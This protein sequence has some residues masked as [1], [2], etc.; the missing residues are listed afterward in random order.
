MDLERIGVEHGVGAGAHPGRAGGMQGRLSVA[1]DPFEDLLAGGDAGAGRDLAPV[2]GG[3]GG[4]GQYPPD[5]ADG[6][7]PLPPVLVGG[8][9][10]EPQGGLGPGVGRLDLHRPA[11]VAVHGPDVDLEP[12]PARRRGAVVAD[13]QGQ[14]VDH[15]VGVGHVVVAADEAPGLEVVGGPRPPARQP[16][17]PDPGPPPAGE[18]GLHRHRLGAG[19][20]DVDLQVVLQVAAHSLQPGHH[21][22]PAALQQRRRPHPRQLQHLRGVDRAPAQD[23]L[24]GPHGPG[25]AAPAAHHPRRP[26]ALE[27]DAVDEGAGGQVQVGPVQHRVEVGPGRAQ[28]PP[29]VNVA[30]EGGEALLPVAVDVAGEG[31]AG[32]DRRLQE[33]LEQ[34]AG[35]RPPLQHQRPVVTPERGA[36]VGSQ[37]ALHPLEVRQAVGVVP[38][39][40]ARIAGPPLVVEGVAALEDHP[41]DAGRP[42][43]HLAPGVVDA[44]AP[45]VGLGLGGVPPVVEA[46]ADGER[47][48]GRHVD[49]H[50]PFPVP[51]SGFDHQ[52]LG[53]PVAAQPVGQDAPGRS[54]A[55]D[56][57]VVPVP[58]ATRQHGS[59]PARSGTGGAFAWRR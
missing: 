12:V 40:H 53:G 3:Q 15:Q 24:A 57:I 48:R 42:A 45:H 20:L 16:L 56:H 25:P 2:E 22:D 43:Q 52:H 38:A 58:H 13:G 21:L 14:E 35:G 36:V 30:V 5:A 31:V 54:P 27:E 41:V 34:R 55:H 29:P 10:V 39:V 17:Q 59:L 26:I 11:G 46:V 50:V 28:P 49:V 7:H 8:Q 37:A 33:G 6:L 32:L 19:V 47:E 1:A 9:V 51:P 23:H 44:P 4:L 18:M